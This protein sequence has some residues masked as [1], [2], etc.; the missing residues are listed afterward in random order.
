MPRAPQVKADCEDSGR[1]GETLAQANAVKKQQ[2]IDG[3]VAG[4]TRP[5]TMAL[6]LSPGT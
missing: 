5:R 4:S 3:L 2:L 6:S 1:L